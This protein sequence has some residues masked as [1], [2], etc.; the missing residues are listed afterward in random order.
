MM[1]KVFETFRRLGNWEASN[2]KQREPSCWNGVVSV[3][4]Y[5]ITIEEIEEPVEVIA[6]R[7]RDLW[8]NSDNYH[9]YEPL[10]KA[11]REIGIELDRSEFGKARKQQPV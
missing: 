4:R 11:A 8:R 2:L 3:R 7:L 6:E 5:R 9:H 10:Q 1:P